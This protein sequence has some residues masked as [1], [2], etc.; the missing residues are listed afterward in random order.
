MTTGTPS[1]MIT[2]AAI[3]PASASSDPTERSISAVITTTVSPAAT[4][5]TFEACRRM[6][7]MLSA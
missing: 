5:A 2:I 1:R 6:L 3:A 7:R 4:I